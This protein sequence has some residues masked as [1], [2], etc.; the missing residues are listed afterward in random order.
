MVKTVSMLMVQMVANDRT[1]VEV[2]MVM[3]PGGMVVIVYSDGGC[4][5]L[6][7]E[8]GDSMNIN[9]DEI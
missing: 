4:G 8:N 7:N 1:L 2:T 3:V 9:E 5:C 6:V